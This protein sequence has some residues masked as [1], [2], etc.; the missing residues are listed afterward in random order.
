MV[1]CCSAG[2]QTKE[3]VSGIDKER[4]PNK[5]G[6]ETKEA[7]NK[8]ASQLIA[9]DVKCDPRNMQQNK[10]DPRDRN[11]PKCRQQ[12]A[13]NVKSKVGVGVTWDRAISEDHTKVGKEEQ[14][15]KPVLGRSRRALLSQKRTL[16][17]EEVA[18]REKKKYCKG[19]SIKAAVLL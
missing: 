8:S 9:T 11:V 14:R 6:P 4:I 13:S 5:R 15:S 7:T 16:R 12:N 2:Q 1:D 10:T 17:A 18:A 3:K 19:L